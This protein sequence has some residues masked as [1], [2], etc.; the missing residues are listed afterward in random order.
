MTNREPFKTL[1]KKKKKK[2]E[3]QDISPQCML[4][5]EEVFACLGLGIF[6]EYLSIVKV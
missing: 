2:K 3:F 1:K 4:C 6:V 5:R